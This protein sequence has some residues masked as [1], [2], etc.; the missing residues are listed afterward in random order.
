MAEILV[1]TKDGLHRLDSA[2]GAVRVEHPGR[3]VSAVAPEGSELWAI[4]DGN[5]VWHTA[6]LDWWFHVADL[7]GLKGGCIAD[8]RAGVVVG[9]SLARLFRVSGE[10]LEPVAAFDRVEGR[11]DWFTPWGGPPDTRSISEDDEVVYANIHVGGI[12]R[13]GDCG[14][15]WQ[16]TI[17][18]HSDVHRV[19]TGGGHVLAASAHGLEVSPDRGQTWSTRREGLHATY[20]RGV[21]VCGDT[22]LVS[23][24]TG[25]GGQRS[26]IYRG[27]LRGSAQDGAFERCREGLPEWFDDNIDSY[28]L[29]AHPNGDLATFASSDGRVYVSTDLGAH[30]SELAS[31]L[32]AV[33]CLL[34]RP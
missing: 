23:A 15:S 27:G 6:G 14:D 21:A 1:G 12:L 10:G 30:W 11:D 3:R 33:E 28:C 9:T 8:T 25:P 24:S 29:D 7:E 22:V 19:V 16:P 18:I 17:A 20:C 26:A 34:A 32:P 31:G 4:L 2:S 5:E 13:S